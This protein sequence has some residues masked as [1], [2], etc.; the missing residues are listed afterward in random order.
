MIVKIG[1]NDKILDCLLSSCFS[2]VLMGVVDTI[3][4]TWHSIM[5]D[6]PYYEPP[7]LARTHQISIAGNLVDLLDISSKMIC[8]E[9]RSE[10]QTLS[11]AKDIILGT[12]GTLICP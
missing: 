3:P 1:V 2:F 10:R 12:L 11:T 6:K 7:P 9:L 8:N 4:S 5:K